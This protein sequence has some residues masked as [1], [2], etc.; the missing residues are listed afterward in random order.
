M[1]IEAIIR[2]YIDK[3]FHLS[4]GTCVNNKPWVC[5]VHFAYDEDLNL[6]FRSLASRRHSQEI[7]QNPNVAGNIVRQHALAD[8]PHGI[9]FEGTAERMTD[10]A[11]RQRVFPYLKNRLGSPDTKLEEAR[12]EDGHQFYKITVS[13]WYAFGQF[14]GETVQKYELAWNP[15]PARDVQA[16]TT[17]AAIR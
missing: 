11:E 15:S 13:K 8:I 3:S 10:D 12:R 1:N 9:Y 17:H 5:E 6:Y 2:E 7:A 4:L 16:D 14:D